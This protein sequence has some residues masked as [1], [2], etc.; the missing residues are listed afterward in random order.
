MRREMSFV[1]ERQSIQIDVTL[2]LEIETRRSVKTKIII[3]G[4][5]HAFI[6]PK[7]FE[8]RSIQ[9]SKTKDQRLMIGGLLIVR[10]M[11]EETFI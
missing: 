10:E 5:D 4:E 6:G 9:F 7:R 3:V 1:Q 11:S 2:T 8:R